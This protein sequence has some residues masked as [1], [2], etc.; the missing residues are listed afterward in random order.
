[1]CV[2]LHC[3]ALALGAAAARADDAVFLPGGSADW[4]VHSNW[5][6]SVYP[7]AAG[8]RAVIGPPSSG[9][10]DVMLRASVTVGSI[11]FPQGASPGRNRIS[12]DAAAALAFAHT[13]DVARIE[14]G[15]TGDGY[16]E[17]E[18]P[19][20]VLLHTNLQLV[21]TNP[22]GSEDYGALRLRQKWSGAG[23]LIK[24]GAGM[25]AL[26]GNDKLFSGPLVIEQGVV[27]CTEPAAPLHAAYVEV[28][29]GGQMRLVS[30][31]AAPRVYQFG[32]PVRIAGYG[33]GAEIP[34]SANLGKLG[35][36]RY[37]VG[38][39]PF[40]QRALIVTSVMCAAGA[41][42]H[43][44][45]VS[46]TLELRG[47]LAGAHPLVKSGAGVLELSGPCTEYTG[48]LIVS[49]GTLAVQANLSA[50]A[51]LTVVAGAR[52]CGTGVVGNTVIKAN[53]IIDPGTA[54]GAGLGVLRAGALTMQPGSQYV[55]EFNSVT[56]DWI[57]AATLSLPPVRRTV[58]VRARYTH[59]TLQDALIATL[60]TF[61][62]TPPNTNALYL[63]LTPPTPLPYTFHLTDTSILVEIV[64]EPAGGLLMLAALGLQMCR[65]GR[66]QIRRLTTSA[67]RGSGLA[68]LVPRARIRLPGPAPLHADSL[69]IPMARTGG[70]N[71]LVA[72]MR[73]AH[74]AAQAGGPP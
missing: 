9:D 1:M 62:G 3:V 11:Y 30:G 25:A 4:N 46:N 37:D 24:R 73:R 65:R 21:I 53:A 18:L 67:W 29:P 69:A 45:G 22:H 36:L 8:A 38:N 50:A 7:D 17:F 44:G 39:E 55:W 57:G 19:G 66:R 10:R 33:R 49:N 71:G 31:G 40:P 43:V 34:D 26:T 63:E 41:D 52:V 32:G 54:P 5:S 13:D 51:S 59:G 16:V 23:A 27:A 28:Q 48:A 6:G 35:A 70:G 72:L 47:G 12:G 14:A 56:S 58:K 60:F 42:V 20:G 68:A 2:L 61:T 64:P 15:G 74:H